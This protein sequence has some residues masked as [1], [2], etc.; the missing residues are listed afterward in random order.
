[1]FSPSCRSTAVTVAC[2]LLTVF[3]GGCSHPEKAEPHPTVEAPVIV[4]ESASLPILHAVA[5][6]V[7]SSTTSTLAANVVGTVV[8]VR[9]AEGDRVRAGEVLVEID[10]REGRAQLDRAKAG[11]Q[12]AE[13]A[14][15]AQ[16]ANAE[17]AESTWRRFEALH[18][19]KSVSEQEFSEARARRTAAQAE[20]SR[21]K[22]RRSEARAAAE[23][24]EALLAY[25]S[26]RA[27]I[28]GVVTARFVDP[29]AQAG[30]G[31]PLITI[32]AERAARVD[33]NVP[34]N[35]TVRVG[36]QA[37]VEAG[38]QHLSARVTRV[39]PSVDS[40]ARS[41]LVQLQLERPLR[42]GTY[43]QVSFAIG[44]RTAVTVPLSALVRRGQLN[45]VFVVG[46]GQVASMR[47]ITVGVVDGLHVEVLSG[48]NA[49]EKIVAAPARVRDGMV[50]RSGA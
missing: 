44:T 49:G 30:P 11:T 38:D 39:Q 31:V 21:L 42:S 4:V 47:L 48:L 25:S 8:R 7:R 12:E 50:V 34:E 41:A 20:L 35:V 5:G 46:A 26:V 15:D 40:G 29:G 18:E 3:L 19:R 37:S 28:D 22:A 1:M 16:A 45:S 13:R 43:V 14:I 17:L 24:A 2:A 36:D 23:Q 33:A 32:E 27:P 6:T 10:A 9:F